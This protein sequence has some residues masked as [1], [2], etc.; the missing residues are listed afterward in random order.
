MN[1][2]KNINIRKILIFIIMTIIII[3]III[4]YKNFNKED[5]VVISNKIEEV[6]VDNERFLLYIDNILENE[7]NIKIEGKILKGSININDEV[8]IVGLGRKEVDS[9]IKGIEINNKEEIEVKTGDK[10]YLIL[11][12]NIKKDFI[13]KGQAVIKIGTT[14]PVFNMNAKITSS[15]LDINSIKK[16]V[17]TFNVNTDIKCSINIISESDK[18]IKISLNTPLVVEKG[19]EVVL[20]NDN[21]I[22]ARAVI[23]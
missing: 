10:V 11:E 23:E 22:I 1:N 17:N 20:K 16:N 15:S 5:N 14:K 2:G 8:G 9:R 19:I 6:T 3:T 21:K 4:I 18:T 7:E 12:S 13:E